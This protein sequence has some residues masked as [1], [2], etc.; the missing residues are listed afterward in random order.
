MARQESRA[1]V[2]L[3]TSIDSLVS[4]QGEITLAGEIPCLGRNFKMGSLFRRLGKKVP[5]PF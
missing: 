1:I 4:S 3:L 2:I 5:E